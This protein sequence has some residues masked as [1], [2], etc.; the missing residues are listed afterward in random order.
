QLNPHFLFNALNA[1]SAEVTR[2]PE[3]AREML[4]QLGGLLRYSLDSGRRDLVPL[5]EEVSFVCDYL[6]LEQARLGD[7]LAVTMDVDPA[8]DA[9]IPPMSLQTLVENAVRH[10]IAPARGGGSLRVQTRRSGDHVEVR[11]EDTG[12]GASEESLATGGVGLA[13]TDERLRLLFGTGLNIERD[14]ASGFAVSFRLPLRAPAGDGHLSAVADAS[15][16]AR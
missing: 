6:A 1:V 15:P 14:R 12:V 7:R 8:L 2:D 11:V 3:E 9:E 13:N 10:G 16:V 5:A 4:G